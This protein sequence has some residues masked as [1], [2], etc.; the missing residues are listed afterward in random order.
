MREQRIEVRRRQVEAPRG[1]AAGAG[2]ACGVNPTGSE[3]GV[4]STHL[5]P[6]SSAPEALLAQ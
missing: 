4:P 3:I 6:C 2:G 1:A 5:A